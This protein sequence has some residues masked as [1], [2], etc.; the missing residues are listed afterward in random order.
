MTFC[1]CGRAV[2]VIRLADGKRQMVELCP[3]P[4]RAS[5]QGRMR[6]IT[7]DG[8]VVQAIGCRPDNKQGIGYASHRCPTMEDT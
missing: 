6:L 5:E 1:A 3:I 4:Y 7:K 2:G 8:L